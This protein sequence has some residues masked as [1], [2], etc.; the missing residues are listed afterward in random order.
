M[1]MTVEVIM[2]VIRSQ[3]V[4]DVLRSTYVCEEKFPFAGLN[5]V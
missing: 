1:F 3:E 5:W 2:K 4:T